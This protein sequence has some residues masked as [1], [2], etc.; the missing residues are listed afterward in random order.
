MTAIP[1]IL[2]A[3]LSAVF[4]FFV[5]YCVWHAR[6]PI[7]RSPEATAV[8]RF[9]ILIPARNEE[10]VIGNLIDS[11]NR[12]D[13]PRDAYSIYAVVNNSTDCTAETARQAGAEV[14]T[15]GQ[16]VSGKGEVLRLAFETLQN[17]EDTDAYIIFDADNVVDSGFLR[18]MNR[19]YETGAPVIQG[20]RIGK[21]VRDSLVSGFYEL[22][23][24]IQNICYNHAQCVSGNSCSLN[25]TG[26]MIRRDWL[27]RNGFETATLTEDLELTARV[28]ARGERVLYA[29]DAVT[30]DEYPT[31]LRMSVR[32]LSRWCFGQKQ[33]MCAYTGN[34]LSCFLGR[35]SLSG[36]N[37]GIVFTA[38]VLLPVYIALLCLSFTLLLRRHMIQPAVIPAALLLALLVYSLM[39]AAVIKACRQRREP[40]TVSLPCI[41][42]FPF[43]MLAWIP[44]SVVSL[45]RR[46]CEW[47]PIA[48]NR[49][50]TIE[51]RQTQAETKTR[52][53]GG[54]LSVCG[55]CIPSGMHSFGHYLLLTS[56]L[57]A[58][59]IALNHTLVLSFFRIRRLIR[60]TA[61]FLWVLELLKIL[62]K[63]KKERSR[64]PGTWVPLYFCSIALYALLLS[65]FGS[66]IWQ[67]VGD[68]FLATGGLCA[69]VCFLAY[70][71]SSL[72]LYP[73]WHFCS[74]HSF[75]YH[76]T[77]I[78]IGVLVSR[79]GL[80][81][82][83]LSDFPLYAGFV[84][85]FCLLALWINR[86]YGSN[87]MFISRPFEGTFLTRAHGFLRGAYTL[88][89]LLVQMVVPFLSII[90]IREITPLL[91]RP[92]WYPPL[93]S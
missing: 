56:T 23:Y 35:H 89:V 41:L 28:I 74:L 85:F 69:G 6:A 83:Q 18:E 53:A 88:I 54:F 47:I 70:P 21:N 4:F 66:G 7:P 38:P 60:H 36:L 13:Y 51:Q 8:R 73:W 72:L 61:V 14:L 19:Q 80:F 27:E 39:I 46:S 65:G 55:D 5:F 48:H 16:P 86:R 34:L 44:V 9:A 33:C 30:Y 45:F 10:A 57:I 50:V 82:L 59:V 68:I 71:S 22:F 12:Q 81:Q 25:G 42:L 17:R 58:V 29:H 92:G 93:G 2:T 62:F 64:D 63:L 31:T 49:S 26:W 67:R 37:L 77:M 76:G 3:L 52:G 79:S 15:I 43:F 91:Q 78:W 11:L 20:R 84:L 40:F 90:I 32:Q 24:L 87:L 75:L 1:F